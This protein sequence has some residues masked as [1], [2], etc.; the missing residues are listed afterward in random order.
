MLN[1]SNAMKMAVVVVVSC[2]VAANSFAADKKQ[3]ATKSKAAAYGQAAAATKGLGVSN[4]G[5]FA[6]AVKAM[7][8]INPKAI[9]AATKIGGNSAIRT[10]AANPNS[11]KALS[12]MSKSKALP[13]A[14][15]YPSTTR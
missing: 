1:R 11:V 5:K 2:F 6:K 8:A 14:G 10:L 3:T 15:R 13:A 9:N 12:A 7:G 4:P